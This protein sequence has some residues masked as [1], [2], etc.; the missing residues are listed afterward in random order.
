MFN[1]I[2]LLGKKKFIYHIFHFFFSRRAPSYYSSKPQMLISSFCISHCK[3]TII[4][5]PSVVYE[6]KEINKSSP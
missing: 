1:Y 6:C 2:D 4:M 3:M 5:G